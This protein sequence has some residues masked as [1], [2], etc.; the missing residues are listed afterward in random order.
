MAL[1]GTDPET[2]ITKYTLVYEEQTSF[3]REGMGDARA[4]ACQPSS[5][6]KAGTLGGL[7]TLVGTVGLGGPTVRLVES[8]G[9]EVLL[10]SFERDPVF[11]ARMCD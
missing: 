2:Y 1:R 7:K 5:V 6:S 4:C 9:R 8:F 11:C 10:Q 3:G